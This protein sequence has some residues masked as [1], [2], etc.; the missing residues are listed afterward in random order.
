MLL[1]QEGQYN[2]LTQEFRDEIEKKVRA[3]G[4]VVRYK[5]DISSNNPDPQKH[6]GKVIW[7][8]VYTLDPATFLINDPYEKRAGKSKSKRIGLIDKVEYPNGNAQVTKFRKIKVDGR[9]KGILKL[10]IEEIEENFWYAVYLELHPK[11]MGGK[12]ADKTKRQIFTRVDELAAATTARTERAAKQIAT[13]YA[14][15]MSER[16]LIDFADAMSG[17]GN[18]TEWD[19]SAVELIL[20]NQIEELAENDPIFFNDLVKG[21]NIEY[22]ALIKRCLNKGVIVFNPAEYNFV[23]GG[24]NQPIVTLSP[25]GEKNEVEK[26][27]EWLQSGGK[28]VYKKIKSLDEAK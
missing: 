20:R 22:Q 2:D 16:Q 14:Q 6:D 28:E 5:F 24:N 9:G 4:K 26:M 8:N 10:E 1:R 15:G 12:F 19:S 18:N 17:G 13:T 3:F 25:N 11:Q 7:P 23:Y 27:A 21:V